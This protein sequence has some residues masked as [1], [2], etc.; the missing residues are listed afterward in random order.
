MKKISISWPTAVVLS[1]VVVALAV[2]ALAGRQLGLPEEAHTEYLLWL[3]GL[4]MLVMSL[5]RPLLT[6]LARDEDGDG[7]P[8]ALQSAE[9][10]R[11]RRRARNRTRFGESE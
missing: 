9:D 8:D 1:V 4:G 10:K 5:M 2:V 11:A 7:I 6:L 3:G